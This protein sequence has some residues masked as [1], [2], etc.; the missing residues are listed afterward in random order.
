MA[1]IFLLL[2]D[3]SEPNNTSLFSGSDGAGF[4]LQLSK[5][6]SDFHIVTIRRHGRRLHLHVHQ[7]RDRLKD[8]C[9]VPACVALLLVYTYR[10]VIQS[11]SRGLPAGAEGA[12]SSGCTEPQ[13]E[14]A[15]DDKKR[16]EGSR[17]ARMFT[18]TPLNPLSR[19]KGTHTIDCQNIGLQ[20]LFCVSPA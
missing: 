1:G 4:Q 16:S 10:A 17:T 6:A 18:S 19:L 5:G 9:T 3:F 14:A 8:S 20:L 7:L 11:I 12:S 13:S 2:S 15:S